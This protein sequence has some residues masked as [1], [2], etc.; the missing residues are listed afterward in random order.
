[1]GNNLNME[2]RQQ[3]QVLTNLGWTDR[4]I[5]LNTGINRGTVAKYKKAF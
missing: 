4:A 1:M 5:S 3:I 2:K